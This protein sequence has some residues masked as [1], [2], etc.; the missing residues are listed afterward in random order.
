MKSAEPELGILA[1]LVRPG[2]TAI[3]VGANRGIYSYALARAGAHVE[4]IEPN[5]ALAHFARTM[6]GRR[7]RVHE[8]ALSNVDG[9][10]TLHIPFGR[11]SV[12]DHLV[13]SLRDRGD[14]AVTVNVPIR[15]MDSFDFKDVSFIK[16]D[17][18]GGELDVLQGGRR[19]ISRDRPNLLIE[20]LAGTHHDPLAAIRQVEAT[21]GYDA[22]VVIGTDIVESSRALGELRG[23]VKTR[24]V[25][26][27]PRSNS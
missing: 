3:D 8:L 27:T 11:R 14:R 9:A 24:N 25:L 17:V 10:G 23:A 1:R 15:T 6:L 13:A 12:P 20:L 26:F 22:S 19:T 4:S 16:V 2:S 18:E 7:A 21:F 5:P